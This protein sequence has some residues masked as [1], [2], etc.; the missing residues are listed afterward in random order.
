[1]EQTVFQAREQN[2]TSQRLAGDGGDE[3]L[4]LNGAFWRLAEVKQTG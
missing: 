3:L 1:M 4:N 2:P